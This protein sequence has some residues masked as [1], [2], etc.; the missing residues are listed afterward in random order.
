MNITINRVVDALNDEWTGEVDLNKIET[1]SNVERD[2]DEFVTIY[3]KVGTDGRAFY[4]ILDQE[5]VDKI[6][7]V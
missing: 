2:S 6:K 7:S 3:C 5:L 4:L 1:V